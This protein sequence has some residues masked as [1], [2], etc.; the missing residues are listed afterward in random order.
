MKR[1]RVT[2]LLLLEGRERFFLQAVVTRERERERE[3][4]RERR[5][6]E[7]AEIERQR[8]R[9]RDGRLS[10][11]K[12]ARVLLAYEP[13]CIEGSPYCRIRVEQRNSFSSEDLVLQT[14][15]HA[16]AFETSEVITIATQNARQRSTCAHV[17]SR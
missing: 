5:L 13:G 1:E 11:E 4:E 15:L 16:T 6:R 12:V 8:Q 9:E 2:R 3:G 7:R 14:P 10:G 17:L